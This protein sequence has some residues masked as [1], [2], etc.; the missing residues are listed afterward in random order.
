MR[1]STRD[2]NR[3][4]EGGRLREEIL[5][6]ATDLLER[7]GN[8][9]AVTLRAIARE[10]GISAPSIYGHFEDREAIVSAVI[11]NAFSDFPRSIPH[12]DRRRD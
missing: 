5:Q 8:A 6:A 2:R 9:E 7:G 12:R 3:R 11:D 10:V 1:K 4:G